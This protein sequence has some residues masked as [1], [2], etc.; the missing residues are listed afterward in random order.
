MQSHPGPQREVMFTRIPGLLALWSLTVLLVGCGS[1]GQD[2]EERP[3]RLVD[4]E[5]EVELER[6]WRYRVGDGQGGQYN[7]LTPAIEG[8]TIYAASVDGEVVALDRSE[9]SR[10][11][12]QRIRD[13]VISGG[14]GTGGD[15]VFIGLTDARVM[16]LDADSGEILWEAETTSEVL[17][18]PVY[19][20]GRV[21]IQTV[22]GKLASLDADNGE[23]QWIYESS[24][25]ALSLRGTSTPQVRD[26]SV[27]AGFGNG[28]VV[29]VALD[30]GTL[31]WEQ[32]VAVPTGRSEIERLVD[33]DGEL[34]VVNNNLIVPSYQGYLAA[35]N[36]ETGQVTWRVSESTVHGPASGFGNLYT[37]NQDGTVRAWRLG[38]EEAVWENDALARRGLSAPATFN[39]YLVVG[40][41]DGY[42]HLLAQSD[43]RFV[44]RLR[45]DR[46]GVR[47]RML[48]RSGT[49]YVYG[50][51]GRLSAYR[52]QQ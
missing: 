20:R 38:E 45:A 18:P 2:D 26:N 3:A 33:I 14:V 28:S 25:P 23:R 49:L 34:L 30:N 19:S 37:V 35:I 24:V 7:R 4:F 48:T 21:I 12:R 1:F 15:R 51:G 16:A 32:R 39:N 27:I 9:G 52:I 47:A 44:G 10:L 50:N 11:W 6:L 41:F 42:L 8:N 43:G 17:A 46:K 40:D 13:A 22:D 36:L 29:A 31:R 5:E